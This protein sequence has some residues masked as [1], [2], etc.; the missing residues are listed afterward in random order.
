MYQ[1]YIFLNEE[2][3]SALLI[4]THMVHRMMEMRIDQNNISHELTILKITKTISL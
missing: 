4:S 3:G 1:R 2:G